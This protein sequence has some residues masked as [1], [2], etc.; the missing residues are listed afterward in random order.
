[1]E[2][3]APNFLDEALVVLDR[4]GAKARVLAG[5]SL[6]GHDLRAAQHGAYAL[7]NVKRISPLAQIELQGSALRVGA[8]ATAHVLAT[9]SLV[10]THAPL[11]AQAAATLGARQ[12]RS[13]ATIGGNVCSG[14]HS[15]DLAVALFASDARVLY[16]SAREG[17][18]E[19]PI[20]TFLAPGFQ[21]LAPGTLLTAF[22]IPLAE[23][24]TAY[25]KMQTRRAFEMALVSVAA[26]VHV[27][28]ET[29]SDARIVLGGAAPTP[30]LAVGAGDSLI[31]RPLTESA[32]RAAADVAADLDADP[33]DDER[34]SAD[35]RRHLVRVLVSRAL[36]RI[37]QG[38]IGGAAACTP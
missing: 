8:L 15:A 9:D 12:L 36:S 6:L 24:L 31:G 29:V 21:G 13:V 23:A 27:R 17:R 14:H 10:R 11:L 37:A 3:F 16:A 33:R 18:G 35:Y 38:R 5:G 32:V 7:V 25:A 34:A 26:R 19:A 4:Y 30:V 1:M 28:G 20:D 22:E 2:Y